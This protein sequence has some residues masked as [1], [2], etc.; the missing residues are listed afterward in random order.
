M[1][2]KTQY[3]VY[4]YGMVARSTLYILD[5]RFVFPK[6][7]GYA[8]IKE[9]H[10][11]LG[12]EAANT[13]VVLSSL[14]VKTII[15]GN[16]IG[17]EHRDEVIGLLAQYDV[18][19]SR[20]S[21]K[22][23]YTGVEEIVFSDRRTRTVFGTYVN[24]LFTK[25]QW[26]T[27]NR[28][29]IEN[30]DAVSLDPFFENESVEAAKLCN[31]LGKKYVTIDCRCESPVAE[32][33]HV[34]ILSREFLNREYTDNEPIK[35]LKKYQQHC[36]GLTIITAGKDDIL[37]SGSRG[38]VETV[39]PYNVKTL[40]TCGAGDAFRAGIIM[41][42]LQNKDDTDMIRFACAV[43]AIICTSFP[44]VL[45]SPSYTDVLHFIKEQKR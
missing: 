34:I 9:K 42:L 31:K 11:M 45:K 20:L 23:D 5:K 30:A 37:F 43:A 44:G 32:N 36:R 33:A 38:N 35:I 24:L 27:P 14:G 18:D 7:D 2:M 12:G 21:A 41:G 10:Q 25:K 22:K 29:D 17:Y 1:V 6:P 4:L 13:A 19:C 39:T 3:C 8:E 26:N 15:D 40:D 16:W 28:R